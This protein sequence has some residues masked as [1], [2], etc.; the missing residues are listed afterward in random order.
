MPAATTEPSVKR[1]CVLATLAAGVW[2]C[3]DSVERD[4]RRVYGCGVS[5][6]G[7]R[8]ASR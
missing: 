1:L 6:A 4:A 2:G 7:G 5:V 3:A 8:R